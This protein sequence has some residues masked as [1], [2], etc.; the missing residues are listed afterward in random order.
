[1]FLTTLRP[2]IKYTKIFIHTYRGFHQKQQ[3]HRKI[4]KL[5]YRPL[6]GR[7]GQ[8]S[9]SVSL[10]FLQ[11][12]FGYTFALPVY[13]SK[14]L[15]GTEE[16][17]GK[18]TRNHREE[19]P[20]QFLL[21]KLCVYQSRTAILRNV[22]KYNVSLEDTSLHQCFSFTVS[23]NKPISARTTCLTKANW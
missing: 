20:A 3:L 19:G 18:I 4:S 12:C 1:M 11:T 7:K 8:F 15:S 21:H 17:G 5:F 9:S 23:N 6:V 10:A 13:H 14:T 2:T 22:L 16:W